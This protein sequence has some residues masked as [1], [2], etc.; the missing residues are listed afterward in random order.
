MKTLYESFISG[1]FMCFCKFPWKDAIIPK[2]NRT[3]AV[4]LT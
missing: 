1:I 4:K 2:K 3:F